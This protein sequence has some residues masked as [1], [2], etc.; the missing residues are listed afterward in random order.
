MTLDDL[1]GRIFASTTEVAQL[2]DG[3]D[4]RTIRRMC[5]AGEIPSKRVGVQYKIPVA[6]L[7]EYLGGK[8]TA[9]ESG[10]DLDRLA[11]RLADRVA[12]RVTARVL[13]AFASLAAQPT[14]SANEPALHHQ[15]RPATTNDSPTGTEQSHAHR[16]PA[17]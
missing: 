2:L 16:N 5:E 1:D 13:G 7:R 15:D 8:R 4:T 6:W 9:E 17:A 14:A 11:E 12:E 3:A 10:P